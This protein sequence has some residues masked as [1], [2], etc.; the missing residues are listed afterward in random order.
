MMFS[1]KFSVKDMRD[2]R[3][4]KNLVAV[5][6]AFFN[7]RIYRT[8]TFDPIRTLAT[9]TAMMMDSDTHSLYATDEDGYIGGFFEFGFER[10]WMAEE[11]MMCINFYIVPEHRRGDCSQMLMD[12]ALEICK[13][14]GAKLVWASSTAGF[15]DNGCNER[16]FKMF[17]KRNR[18]REVG[19]FLVWEPEHEQIQESCESSSGTR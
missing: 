19:T 13:N 4:A 14:R 11:V 5:H 15:S 7:E 18:F 9:I 16:A 1:R 12:K 2:A 10:P 8:M 6:E 3:Y 17:L